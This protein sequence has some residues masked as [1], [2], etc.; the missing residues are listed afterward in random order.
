[1]LFPVVEIRSN[2]QKVNKR[3]SGSAYSHNLFRFIEIA[4]NFL[5]FFPS[6]ASSIILLNFALVPNCIFG[7]FEGILQI[8]LFHKGLRFLSKLK[9]T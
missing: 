6:E 5:T 8:Q 4:I 7:D 3:L 2:V 1:M 9:M